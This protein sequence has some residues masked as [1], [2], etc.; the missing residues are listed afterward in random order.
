MP[1]FSARLKKAGKETAG[2]PSK[3]RTETSPF[4]NGTTGLVLDWLKGSA[5]ELDGKESLTGR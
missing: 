1:P 4:W 2:L 5:E 3:V